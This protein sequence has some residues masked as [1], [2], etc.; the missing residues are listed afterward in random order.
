[1]AHS[2]AAVHLNVNSRAQNFSM[3]LRKRISRIKILPD[4]AMYA[5]RLT[6]RTCSYVIS[7][8]C[9]IYAGLLRQMVLVA[10]M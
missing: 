6:C 3:L 5:K 1:M 8:P 10:T 7:K 4:A 2:S 9:L